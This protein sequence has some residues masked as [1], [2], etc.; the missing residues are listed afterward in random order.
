MARKSATWLYSS[1]NHLLRGA[2]THSQPKSSLKNAQLAVCTP[3]TTYRS[4]QRSHP[5]TATFGEQSRIWLK[6]LV[7][8]DCIGTIKAPISITSNLDLQSNY[9]P[10]VLEEGPLWVLRRSWK[11]LICNPGRAKR[12]TVDDTN[13]A[14]HHLHY[15]Y[16][17]S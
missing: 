7:Y 8:E 3:S 6:E 16:H 13:P 5:G 1:R 4:C 2:S 17:N 10:M 15:K 14:R 11:F 12:D 9:R